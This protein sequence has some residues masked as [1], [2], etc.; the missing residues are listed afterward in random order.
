MPNSVFKSIF[1]R[2]SRIDWKYDEAYRYGSQL[3]WN[4]QIIRAELSDRDVAPNKLDIVFD[5]LKRSAHTTLFKATEWMHYVKQD[6]A[7]I[8]SNPYRL[9][10]NKIGR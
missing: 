3:Q 10:Q 4:E 1:V 7:D 6:N 5:G 8:Y 9:K 2:G